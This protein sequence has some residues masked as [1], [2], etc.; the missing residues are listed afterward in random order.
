[1]KFGLSKIE[2]FI[3]LVIATVIYTIPK[4]LTTE[5]SCYVLGNT[6]NEIG[7][8]IGGITAPFLSFFGSILVYLALKAQVNANN[9][10]Q[11][12]FELQK[13][14]SQFYEMLR[15]HRENVNDLSIEGKVVKSEKGIKKSS[16]PEFFPPKEEIKQNRESFTFDGRKVFP[17][18][19]EE[20]EYAIEYYE[21]NYCNLNSS[22]KID[23]RGFEKCYHIFFLGVNSFRA[24][25]KNDSDTNLIADKYAT[26]SINNFS[27]ING[28]EH[29]LA[30]RYLWFQG[31]VDILAHYYRHLFQLVKL[32]ANQS[33]KFID[34]EQKRMYLRIV[35][36][37]LSNDEQAL[38]FYNWFSKLG[39]QWEN[40]ENKYFTDYRMIHNLFQDNLFNSPV[41]LL[42]NIFND[43]NFKK[44]KGRVNDPLFESDDL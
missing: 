9:Q 7:D 12:Q 28:S 4:I 8:S 31:H 33:E 27:N 36:S 20:L 44:E 23:K 38:L 24:T 43:D 11:K 25:Y 42:A 30:Y 34:Y 39:I 26:E 3:F 19:K 22:K 41:F 37:Q 21:L 18:I 13:F 35:R 17:K 29:F 15:I 5:S 6:P 14:E 2:I 32:I 16:L 10:F 40:N 1:M